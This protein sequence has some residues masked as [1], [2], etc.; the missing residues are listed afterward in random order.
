[1]RRFIG[2]AASAA[3][4]MVSAPAA[5]EPPPESGVVVRIEATDSFGVFPDFENGYWVFSNVTRDAFC[6]WFD[7]MSLPLPT[8]ETPDD[9][10]LIFASD[11]LAQLGRVGGPT[12]LHAFTEDPFLDPC[13]GSTADAALWGDVQVR[14][15][16][17]DVPNEGVRANSFGD[18]GQGT[19]YDTE[20]G[21]YHY[22]WVFRALWNPDATEFSVVKET[23][24]LH[25]IGAAG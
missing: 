7:D 12:W 13:A 9:I 1:M 19:L 20:G 24:N 6:T 11:A 10:Q 22:S 17:N 23:F 5:A 25:P 16:D 14:T 18:R 2:L 21:T 4:I 3:V 8:N 15:N